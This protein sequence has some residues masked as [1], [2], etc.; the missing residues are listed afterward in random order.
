VRLGIFGGTF[1]PVHH[2]HLIIADYVR[3][4]ARLDKVIFVPSATSPHKQGEEVTDPA[5]RLAMLNEGVGQNPAF[6]VSE[7]E[8]KRGG[9]SYSVD[10]IR[11]VAGDHPKDQ[12]FLMIGTDTLAEF[13]TWKDPDE[14]LK[15]AKLIAFK[16]P[17][18]DVDPS[19][20]SL[21]KEAIVCDV[22]GL[23]IS[24]TQI[25]KRVAEGLPIGLMVPEG[26]ER[27]ISEHGL[28]KRKTKTQ[29]TFSNK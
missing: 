11:E 29:L 6:E 15:M 9:V 5:D 21:V 17:G 7:M 4:E 14:I 28:Y 3:L 18:H 8:I 27:Y 1:D 23:D 19:A 22:P 26:V 13:K 2:A 20:E 12:L 16:R 10:T 24:S 25:R